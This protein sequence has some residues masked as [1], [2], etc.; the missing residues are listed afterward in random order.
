MVNCGKLWW[1]SFFHFERFYKHIDYIIHA[2][3]IEKI[4]KNIFHAVIL[5]NTAF[6]FVS[7]TWNFLIWHHYDVIFYDYKICNPDNSERESRLKYKFLKIKKY[8]SRKLSW[9]E[10]WWTDSIWPTF[11]RNIE[12]FWRKIEGF[13][14]N[15]E[16]FVFYFL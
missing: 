6:Q 16:I 12:G 1:F 14:R 7:F 11:W 10:L 2:N 3:F 15:T 8:L 9:K 4:V 13:W 5:K